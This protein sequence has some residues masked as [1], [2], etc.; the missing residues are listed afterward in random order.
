MT[1]VLLV[2]DH[3]LMREGVKQLLAMDGGIVVVAEASNGA[4]A[5]DVMRSEDID[6]VLLDMSMPGISGPDLIRHMRAQLDAPQILVLSMH[7]EVQVVRRTLAAGACGYLTK[8]CHPKTLINAIYKV[9]AGGR[10]I[11]PRLTEQLAYAALI[12]KDETLHERLSG[13]EYDIFRLLVGGKSSNE[14]ARDLKISN[15]TVS[16][17]KVR[18]MKKLSC[19]NGAQLLRYAVTHQLTEV[20]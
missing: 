6:V 11:D 8:D 18:L 14:I 16:T 10:V 7:N 9:S 5:M 13:R 3:A 12:S 2:D 19:E 20:I 17:H 1:R 15:K 4:Q